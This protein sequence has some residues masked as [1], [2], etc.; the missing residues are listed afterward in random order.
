MR[1]P[2]S[3]RWRSKKQPSNRRRP[4]IWR[5]PAGAMRPGRRSA[6][7]STPTS[8]SQSWRSS[9]PSISRRRPA[10]SPIPRSAGMRARF[11]SGARLHVLS[12]R[13]RSGAVQPDRHPAVRRRRPA[14][15]GRL[16]IAGVRVADRAVGAVPAGALRTRSA[17]AR[18]SDAG[19]GEGSRGI[20]GRLW[21][22]I[23]VR[24]VGAWLSLVEHSVR[25]R[26]VGGSNPLA[27][28]KKTIEMASDR[29]SWSVEGLFYW[30]LSILS[31]AQVNILSKSGL[32]SCR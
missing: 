27:P 10:P 20:H 5:R 7:R 13:R 31:P 4:A 12:G 17:G 26:G 14:G 3:K 28:T 23:G 2:P 19:G 15:G 30:L 11:G 8:A 18:S 9:R 22:K 21:V 16:G 24:C 29:P 1:S 6:S 25:D 32:I